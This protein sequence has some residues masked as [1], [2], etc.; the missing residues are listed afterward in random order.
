MDSTVAAALWGTEG[1]AGAQWML[2]APEAQQRL[3][4]V[5]ARLLDDPSRLTTCQ[6]YRAKFKP[7]RKLTAYYHVMVAGATGE[8]PTTRE[9]ALA[10]RPEAESA[11][12]EPTA[13]MAAM[14]EEAA[15]HGLLAPFTT[16]AAASPELGMQIQIAPL[17]V[18]FPQLVPVSDPR[19]VGSLAAA[20]CQAAESSH[21]PEVAENYEVTAIRYRPGQR[22][23]LRYEPTDAAADGQDP[24]TLFAK[25]YEDARECTRAYGVAARVADW[26]HVYGDG[27]SA[28]RPV[29]YSADD[30]VILYPRLVGVPLSDKLGR[31]LDEVQPFLGHAGSVLRTLH[32]RPQEIADEFA[33]ISS[34]A[35]A[36]IDDLKPHSFSKEV[37]A[38]ARTCEHIYE[39]L[40]DVGA[41]VT[42]ILAQAQEA[43]A[44]I[45]QE[46]PTFAHGDYK[47]DHLWIT[48]DGLTLMDFDTCYLADPAI[49]VGKFL[50]DMHWWSIGYGRDDIAQLREAFLASY[51]PGAPAARLRRARIYEALV[52]IKSTAHRVRIFDDHWAARTTELIE[53]AGQIINE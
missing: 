14:Q 1:L 48:G 21:A 50:S 39:L 19:Y 3:A 13:A 15:A 44:Q 20:I 17:D 38:I 32:R 52:L 8:P 9:A 43:Y 24:R 47:A 18:E 36:L 53:R 16:L 10:W 11:A 12:N 27:L 6:L 7:G 34:Q 22:H 51:A 5:M 31:P 45:P 37:K 46:D 49:D 28:L 30:A 40:P 29:G 33:H 35:A 42:A 26:L 2:C 41:Q 4:N 25:L 23:V